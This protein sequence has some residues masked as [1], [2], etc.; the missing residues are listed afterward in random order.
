MRAALP[1]ALAA[2]GRIGTQPPGAPRL[3]VPDVS[4]LLNPPGFPHPSARPPSPLFSP[5]HAGERYN[6]VR[7][8]WR[9]V[10][11]VAVLSRVM[12]GCVGSAAAR[13]RSVS[14]TIRFR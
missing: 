8:D 1:S 7:M 4:R 5:I 13:P 10:Q 3:R 2:M 6:F 11:F 12:P 14:R 9:G